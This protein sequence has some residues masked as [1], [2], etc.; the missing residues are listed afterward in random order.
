MRTLTGLFAA[1]VLGLAVAAT[2]G[3]KMEW[4]TSGTVIVTLPTIPANQEPPYQA[5]TSYTPTRYDPCP[6]EPPM[7]CVRRP[8]FVNHHRWPL[9][10]VDRRCR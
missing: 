8:V 6:P 4:T 9:V 5:P 1:V 3:C 2:T 7:I 10:V